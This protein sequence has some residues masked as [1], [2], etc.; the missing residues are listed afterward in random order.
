MIMNV[1]TFPI[2]IRFNIVVDL[3]WENFFLSQEIS[4]VT[5]NFFLWQEISSCDKRFPPC[6][7]R[8]LPGDKISF[9]EKKYL[10][11]PRNFFLWLET[12]SENF[13]LWQEISSCDRKSF[14][15]LEVSSTIFFSGIGPS[16][17]W[18]E[19]SEWFLLKTLPKN[20]RPPG[21]NIVTL[22]LRF[23]PVFWG[24]K[25]KWGV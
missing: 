11:M 2:Q 1:A 22:P 14:L 5:G 19:I 17:S 20:S 3:F 23:H 15:W 10:P 18:Q 12:S 13:F 16:F 25:V 6:D 24:G 8:Y 7:R 4:S 9:C 21:K